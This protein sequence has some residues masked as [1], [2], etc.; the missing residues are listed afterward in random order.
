MGLS[1]YPTIF[2][3][4]RGSTNHQV[5]DLLHIPVGCS[6]IY[7]FKGKYIWEIYWRF[8]MDMWY[9]VPMMGYQC[10]YIYIHI[11]PVY[12]PYLPVNPSKYIK[13]RYGLIAN[14]RF[15]GR[16]KHTR[17]TLWQF[18]VAIEHGYRNSWFTHKI[19]FRSCLP[20]GNSIRP[21]LNHH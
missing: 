9:I 5:Q 1:V 6:W 14:L 10:V 19:D 20:K 16:Y 4:R 18:N 8:D 13:N 2:V 12:L 21:P 3:K 11:I 15:D 17:S 7:F